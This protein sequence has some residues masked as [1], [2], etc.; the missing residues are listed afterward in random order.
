MISQKILLNK[1]PIP[2]PQTPLPGCYHTV[3]GFKWHHQ[4]K[5]TAGVKWIFLFSSAHEDLSTIFFLFKSV[6]L[7]WH[8]VWPNTGHLKKKKKSV[9]HP[10]SSSHEWLCFTFYA[11]S[12][13][14]VFHL[15]SRTLCVP[16][17]CRAASDKKQCLLKSSVCVWEWVEA[18]APPLHT[19]LDW[20]CLQDLTGPT[21]FLCM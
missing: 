21:G 11:D 9:H 15:L 16:T 20:L 7:S 5:I 2:N 14:C 8:T 10:H 17:S 12:C 4:H 1:S 18:S 19:V 3:S 6:V 13:I